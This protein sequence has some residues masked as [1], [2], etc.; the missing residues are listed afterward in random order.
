MN[1]IEIEGKSPL[2]K[3]EPKTELNTLNSKGWVFFVQG[4]R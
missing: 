2:A 1:K 4:G 3:G